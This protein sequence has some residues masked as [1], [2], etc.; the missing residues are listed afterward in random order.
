MLQS[1]YSLTLTDG[2]FEAKALDKTARVSVDRMMQGS[3]FPA[4]K[5][6]LA[7]GG[8]E[9]VFDARGIGIKKG[10]Q[11]A[12]SRVPAIATTP[13]INSPA[14]INETNRLIK[15]GKREAGFTSLSGYEYVGST[16]YVLLRWEDKSGSTWLEA[17][18]G[19]DMSQ[20]SL[21]ANVVGR[22]PGTS[23]ARGTVDDQLKLDGGNLVAL[24]Q[25]NDGWGMGT[26]NIAGSEAGLKVYGERAS[27]ARFM[28]G[29]ANAV[30][31]EATA[32]GTTVAT[33]VDVGTGDARP[34]AEVRGAIK[35]VQEP[36]FL[37]YIKFNRHYLRNLMSGNEVEIP[38]DAAFG[39]TD[40]G[41]IVW[42]PME[43]PTKAWFMEADTGRVFAQWA[44]PAVPPAVT[45]PGQ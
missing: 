6:T 43:N 28:N 25:G 7:Y 33:W 13:K 24:V 35:G 41:L 34:I 23:F 1:P 21:T 22:F 17:L 20:E 5:L 31:L 10:N 2:V 14:E 36:H 37:R 16:L 19:I 40:L 26:W 11:V 12:W 29:M 38:S 27:T 44:V 39:A 15:E 18:A 42:T 30:G 8:R 9:V 3:V 45:P 32:Y 4:E